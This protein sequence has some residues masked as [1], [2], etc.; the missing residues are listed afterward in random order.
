MQA[1]L[2]AP[3]TTKETSKKVTF[4]YYAASAWSKPKHGFGL[5]NRCMHVFHLQA[6]CLVS[7]SCR[8]MSKGRL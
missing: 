7:V 4:Y 3:M 2:V 5:V 1:S 8:E 6:R